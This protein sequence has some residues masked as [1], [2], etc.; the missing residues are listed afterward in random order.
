RGRHMKRPFVLWLTAG[1]ALG[2]VASLWA[3]AQGAVLS[4]SA[5]P[6]RVNVSHVAVTDDLNGRRLANSPPPVGTGS[7]TGVR[8]GALF[9]IDKA[10]TLETAG[11]RLGGTFNFLF[12]GPHRQRY[13]GFAGH[14]A[15]TKGG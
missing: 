11:I 9:Y 8:P 3:T 6:A 1:L 12:R 15:L 5:Q 13:M 4:P 7:C 10:Y 14:T 2:A